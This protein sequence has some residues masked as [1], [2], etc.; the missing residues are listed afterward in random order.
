MKTY[1]LLVAALMYACLLEAQQMQ[2]GT[3]SIISDA[4]QGRQTS[5][6]IK[7]DK[8][9][10]TCAHNVHPYGSRLKVT[11]LDNN[12]VVHVR[13]IDEGPYM[14]GRIIELSGRAAEILGMQSND[15]A[16][17]RVELEKRGMGIQTDTAARGQNSGSQTVLPKPMEETNRTPTSTLPAATTEK[18]PS[19]STSETIPAFSERKATEVP[20]AKLVR[21]D[22]TQFGLYQVQLR[23]PALQGWGVQ[24]SS[25]TNPEYVFQEIA[26]LQSKYL[27][28]I[29]LSIEKGEVGRTQYKFILGPFDTEERA[30]QYL[31]GLKKRFK[32]D[33]FVVN[34]ARGNY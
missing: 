14:K 28:N 21:D 31:A 23:K 22:Y 13:V 26:R 29:L 10:L 11:R 7:Y 2:E 6:G 16:L 32:M 24:V 9:E 19:A 25:S 4:F 27:D 18:S 30:R 34:L 17:V 1:N 12:R 3:A 20:Q 33:G 15:E 8:R 5:Y